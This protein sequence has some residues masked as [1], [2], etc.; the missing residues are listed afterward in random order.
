MCEMPCFVLLHHESPRGAHFD[1]MIEAGDVLKTWALPR[2]PWPGEEMPCEE[3]ADHRL[4]YLDY[5]GPISNDR[6]TVTRC[7]RGIYTVQ[8][9]SN[10][11]W[12]IDLAGESLVGR[13][14]LERIADQPGQW[15]FT[16]FSELDPH[17]EPI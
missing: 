17:R 4:A 8:T 7:D 6:G 2:L 11:L 1:L 5:E 15:R 3:L 9:Q 13:A 14:R 16:Y 12:V 10:D